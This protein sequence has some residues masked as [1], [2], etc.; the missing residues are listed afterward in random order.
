M[1][2][3]GVVGFVIRWSLIFALAIAFPWL[4]C[5]VATQARGE[6]L[7]AIHASEAKLL[8]DARDGDLQLDLIDAA[9]I[10]SGVTD[11][12]ERTRL[13]RIRDERYAALG[14]GVICN[15]PVQERAPA[16]LAAMHRKLLR[17][18]FRPTAT[19]I[20][21][22]LT[23]GDFNCV[24]ATIL[25]HD[26]CRRCNVPVEIVAQS[27]HVAS[28]LTTV[29]PLEIETT[30]EDWFD[31]PA[32]VISQTAKLRAAQQ[33]R[34]ISPAEL[35]GRVYYN[36]ALAALEQKQFARAIDLLRLSLALDPRDR[37]AHEN[38]LAGLNNW[39]LDLCDSNEFAAAAERIADGLQLQ[40]DHAQLRS[41]DLHV[42]Q[43]WV[44][45]LCQQ[46]DFRRAIEILEAGRRRRPEA[47]LFNAGQRAVY[48]A[49]LK[50]CISAGDAA[51]AAQVLRESHQKFG[52]Q[53]R[54][55]L[56][57]RPASRVTRP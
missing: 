18:A 45:H 47:A 49:W 37:D 54:L 29:P 10:S 34:V 32:D 44:T 51:T 38:L 43:K 1:V 6:T 56:E 50:H 55:T 27:G 24:T 4:A 40:A 11:R 26:L 42:H 41:N 31:R 19:L 7:P 35:L 12:S 22:T 28:R 9:L 5:G 46:H 20:Q 17:G 23:G 13:L 39:A 8:A 25:F 30:R 16:L 2:P 14:L 48:E 36:R 53:A 3:P 21:E 33:K 57:A 15:L 52:P